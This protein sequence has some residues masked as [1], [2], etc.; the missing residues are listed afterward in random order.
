MWYS[1]VNLIK[2]TMKDSKNS[3][4]QRKW[5][6]VV[7]DHARMQQIIDKYDTLSTPLKDYAIKHRNEL[8]K[9]YPLLLKTI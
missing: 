3:Y 9:A 7:A 5:E 2:G 4:E 1:S 8:E 6:F